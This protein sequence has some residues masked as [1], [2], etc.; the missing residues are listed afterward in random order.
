MAS[1]DQY[2]FLQAKDFNAVNGSTPFPQLV[3]VSPGIWGLPL[4]KLDTQ[5]YV[6]EF[7][8]VA[9]LAT[10]LTIQTAIVEDPNT[11]G[12]TDAGKVVRLGVN[13][14]NLATGADTY[15]YTTSAGTE[16]E[17][18]V[19]CDATSGEIVLTST[20]CTNTDSIAAGGRGLI[21]IRRIGSSSSDT[22]KGRVV[23]MGVS[24]RD[25]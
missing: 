23:L 13:F 9:G 1:G 5:Y 19:T 17:F 7:R 24:I 11:T 8:A 18:S 20:A 25:T 10:G 16:A 6:A 12:N 21:I 2:A 3:Q 14:K 22:H 4:N 15:D